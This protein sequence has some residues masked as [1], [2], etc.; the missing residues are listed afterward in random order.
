M[1]WWWQVGGGGLVVGPGQR[2]QGST[3]PHAVLAESRAPL[4]EVWLP[5]MTPRPRR[6]RRADSAGLRATECPI[7]AQGV[8]RALQEARGANLVVWVCD[9]LECARGQQEAEE[10]QQWQRQQQQRRQLAGKEG[11]SRDGCAPGE[12][13]RGV[14]RGAAGDDGA[15][16]LPVLEEARAAL[17]GGGTGAA[18]AP[19]GAKAGAHPQAVPAPLVLVALNKADLL[20]PQRVARLVAGAR[21]AL[22]RGAGAGAALAPARVRVLNPLS[23]V[24]GDGLPAL[25]SALERG[26]H[27]A[28][29]GGGAAGAHSAPPPLLTRL[30]HMQLVAEAAAHLRRAVE[31]GGGAPEV[32]AEEVRLAEAALAQLR[33]GAGGRDV[34]AM[35]DALFSEFC[36]GK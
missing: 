31:A 16:L 27:A 34:E 12:P 10:Q 35:L 19:A 6:R 2:K 22:E 14:E 25:L 30:R 23:C 15:W 13:G 32:A 24:T 4:H 33:G 18:A 7:E 1:P 29:F 9:A 21:Q 28:V 36:I 3:M 20:P 17:L 5:R 26:A 11:G 8:S